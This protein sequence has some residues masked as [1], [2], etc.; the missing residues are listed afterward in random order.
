MI[1]VEVIIDGIVRARAV[2]VEIH[3]E[4]DALARARGAKRPDGRDAYW[5][6][7]VV[8]LRSGRVGGRLVGDWR[9]AVERGPPLIQVVGL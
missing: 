6:R 4:A 8:C 9:R 3:V 1:R 2:Q 5:C 7:V